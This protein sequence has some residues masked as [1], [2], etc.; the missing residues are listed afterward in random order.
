MLVQNAERLEQVHPSLVKLVYGVAPYFPLIVI[1]GERNEEEQNLAFSTGK[2]KLKW[3]HSKH[4]IVPPETH[5]LAVD[6]AP[7]PLDWQDK[8]R[9][10]YFAGFVKARAITN[11]L[12]IRWGGDWNMNNNLK[13]QTFFDLVHYEIVE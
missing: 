8:E 3:P 9:F 12:T 4:N 13:D 7:L 10:Y 1:C 2:S 5:C 6:I 11:G